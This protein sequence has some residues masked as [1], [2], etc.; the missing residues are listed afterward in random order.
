MS[1]VLPSSPP[2]FLRHSCEGG[3]PWETKSKISSFFWGMYILHNPILERKGE[4][5][6]R[7]SAFSLLRSSGPPRKEASAI[8]FI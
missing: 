5:L 7:F 6:L 4:K 8:Y 2:R 1:H 3:D